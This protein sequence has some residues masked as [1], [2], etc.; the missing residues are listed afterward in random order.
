[1]MFSVTSR[2]DGKAFK[3]QVK[4]LPLIWSK[5]SEFG[6]VNTIHVD[7][8]SRNFALNP[9]NVGFLSSREFIRMFERESKF[10]RLEIVTLMIVNLYIWRCTCKKYPG[11][12]IFRLLIIQNGDV[13]S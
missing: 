5:L 6:P 8:L 1:M 3:H 2:K 7:D 4:A 11:Y 10:Q 12:R 13:K 9:K